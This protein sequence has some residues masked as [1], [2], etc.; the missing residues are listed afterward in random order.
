MCALLNSH[1][2]WLWKVHYAH[3]YSLAVMYLG[4]VEPPEGRVN[5]QLEE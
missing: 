3:H 4:P 1:L 2:A 5:S